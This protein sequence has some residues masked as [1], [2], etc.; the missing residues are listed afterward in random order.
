MEKVETCFVKKQTDSLAKGHVDAGR[1]RIRMLWLMLGCVAAFTMEPV[2]ERSD[3]DRSDRSGTG[4]YGH[5]CRTLLEVCHEHDGTG[6][7]DR[8]S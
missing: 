6:H 3:V 2:A 7:E 1:R 4:E 8:A 5:L